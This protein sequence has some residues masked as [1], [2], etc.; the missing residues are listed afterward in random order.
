MKLKKLMAGTLAA[1]M[2]LGSSVMVFAETQ[3]GGATGTGTSVG[4]VDKEV[5]TVTLPTNTDSVF[6]YWV[7]PERV[8]DL[9][10]SLSDGTTVTKNDDGV[11]FKQSDNTYKSSS[12]DVEFE[13]KNSVAVDVS[14]AAEVTA[15]AGGKDIEL[16]ADEDALTAATTPALLMKLTVGTDTK[17]ITSEGAAAKAKLDGVPNNFEV[18]V[19]NGAYVYSA[20]VGATGWAK[21]AV[22]LS[23]K[24]NNME[25][26]SDMTAP[27]IKLTWTIEK[28]VDSYLSATT[29]TASSNSVTL[30]LP[31]ETTLSKVELT[32]TDGTGAA[33]LTNGS[34]YT[35]TGTTLTVPAENITS[36]VGANYTKVVVTFSDGKSE[37]ITLQ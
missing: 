21:T 13:G 7:D 11:Y 25:I 14:V 9:A 17:A 37:I 22:K 15:N 32:L 24:T 28:H 6:N 31:D 20:K 35:L 34:Q 5:L 12:N 30:S 23:G 29:M 3:A 2:V 16:V 27:A 33:E 10:G 18:K 4:H 1:T 19:D 8:I 36:W 26:S